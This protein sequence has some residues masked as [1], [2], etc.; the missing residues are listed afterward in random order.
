MNKIIL[1][2]PVLL[3][4]IFPLFSGADIIHFKDGKQIKTK[5]A[6]EEDGV[7]KCYRFGQIVGY[8]QKNVKRIEKEAIPITPRK[9]Q[10]KKIDDYNSG[11]SY[12]SGSN[13]DGF[14]DMRWGDSVSDKKEFQFIGTDPSYGG[15][16]KYIR[17]TDNLKIGG[18]ELKRIVYNFWQN[19]LMSVTIKFQGYVNYNNL[20]E[21]CIKRFGKP[22]RPNQFMEKYC[23]FDTNTYRLI[24]YSDILKNGSLHM[25]SVYLS[26]ETNAFDERR[27]AEGAA[28]G[29]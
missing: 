12:Y 27:A 13:N 14:R 15:V 16:K 20:L 19:K 6:W 22:Y 10:D 25:S 9:E 1:I 26:K 29:F 17:I 5:Q 18:A 11:S 23:W 24:K 28:K 4:L 21:A 8:P 7:V 2:F 3:A